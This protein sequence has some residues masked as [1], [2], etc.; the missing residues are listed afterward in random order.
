MTDNSKYIVRAGSTSHGSYETDL[1]PKRAGWEWSSL[2]VL[3]LPD[4]ETI[5]VE[6]DETEY[7]VLPL[8]GGCTVKVENEE[9][10]IKGRESVFTDITDYA[11]IPRNQDITITASGHARIALPGAQATKDLSPR[12]CPAKK[13]APAFV[14]LAPPPGR[15][16]TTHLATRLKPRTYLHAK[17]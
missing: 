17:F 4:S 2:R 8:S 9:Y 14:A 13:L 16:T 1:D 11:Y 15:S 12:Y 7:L 5:T 10:E 3:N 6:G